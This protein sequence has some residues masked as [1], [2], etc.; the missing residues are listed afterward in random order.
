V[1]L[2]VAIDVND[3][4]RTLALSAADM[5]RQTGIPGRFEPVEKLHVTV[6]FL[7]N[8]ADQALDGVVR[9]LRE[10]SS[11]RPFGLTFDRLG[12]YPNL[13]RPHVIW[14]GSTQ[15]DPA[16]AECARRVRASFEPLGFRF[17]HEAQPHVTICR[18][19]GARNLELPDLVGSA[20]LRVQG[21][22]LYRS[23]PAGPTTRYEAIDRT[24]F[25]T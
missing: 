16:F 15:A 2:F 25:P 24:L 10:N 22:V 14:I 17:E 9:T 6:A 5:L 7:G 12:A 21:L 1:R 19:K 18:P 4:V 13:R 20:R 23:L 8:V 11:L 3:A